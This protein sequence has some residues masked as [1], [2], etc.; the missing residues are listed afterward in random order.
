MLTKLG[1]LQ[2]RILFTLKNSP[3]HGYELMKK[4]KVTGDSL[5]PG[6]I[7]PALNTLLK[8]KLIDFTEK[9]GSAA[10]RKIY[11]LTEKGLEQLALS[12]R[13]F[14]D[15]IIH[16][17]NEDIAR[18]SVEWYKKYLN[19]HNGSNIIYSCIDTVEMYKILLGSVGESGKLYVIPRM[20]IE[21]IPEGV[22]II[23]QDGIDNLE[24]IDYAII[25][26]NI[27]PLIPVVINLEMLCK[28]LH[29]VLH[30]HGIFIF[31][32][33]DADNI[34]IKTLINT[35]MPVN[36][37]QQYTEENIETTMSKFFCFEKIHNG[38]FITYLCRNS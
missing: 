8:M 28:K 18:Y 13:T 35:F 27:S 32:I 5:S 1:W 23:T 22:N 33:V 24:N 38:G 4:L 19:I 30:K 34:I 36:I 11:Y 17:I 26:S 16:R 2:I 20:N 25:I 12:E 29:K 14:F 7:Y 21:D 6:T 37:Q 3:T 15:S 31:V 9:K 10:K